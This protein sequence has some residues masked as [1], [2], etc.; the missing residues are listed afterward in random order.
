[1]EAIPPNAPLLRGKEVDLHMFV[2]SNHAGNK[3]TR[4]SRTRFMFYMNMSLVNCY[5]NKQSTIE[6]SVL[7]QSLWP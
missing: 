5:S 6:T 7:A 1:M 4:R 2:D 3:Q